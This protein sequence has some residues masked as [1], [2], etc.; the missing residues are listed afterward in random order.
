VTT[1]TFQE[2]GISFH[3]THDS[4]RYVPSVD[5]VLFVLG[6]A[7]EDT[8]NPLLQMGPIYTTNV[9]RAVVAASFEVMSSRP[10]GR[11]AVRNTE[12]QAR[13]IARVIIDLCPEDAKCLLNKPFIEAK[14]WAGD[15]VPAKGT[16]EAALIDACTCPEHLKFK[17]D[18]ALS[19]D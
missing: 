13:M 10:N 7:N 1:K 17:Q 6:L 12:A 4:R 9:H 16:D 15:S 5:A 2:L 3:S 18:R 11:R 19:T 8:R 14:R